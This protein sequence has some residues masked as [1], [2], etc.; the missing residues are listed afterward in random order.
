MKNL[1]TIIPCLLVAASSFSQ[2]SWSLTGNAG[3]N[4]STSFIGTTDNTPFVFKVGGG[5]PAGFSGY[6]ENRNVSYGYRSLLNVANGGTGTGLTAIGYGALANNTSGEF[7]TALG[8]WALVANTTGYWNV[9]L[10][11]GALQW[12][13]TGRFNSAGGN[14]S[15]HFNETGIENTAFGEQ[16]LGGNLDGNFNTAVGCRSLW[17]VLYTPGVGDSGYGHSECNTAVGYESLKVITKGGWNVGVGVRALQ[18]NSAGSDN[19]AVGGL[20]LQRNTTGIGNTAVGNNALSNSKT[21]NY[22]TAIGYGANIN[23]DDITNSTAIGNGAMV[24][25]SNQIVIGNKNVTSIRLTVLPSA[26]SDRRV[27]ENIQENVPGLKFIKLLR[28]V[29]YH[30][31]EN[32]LDGFLKSEKGSELFLGEDAM[33]KS[34]GAIS[35]I[36]TGFIAQEVESAA[37]SIGYS[38][39]AIDVP[40]NKDESLYGLR[41]AKFV[42]PIVKSVQELS[43]QNDVQDA[44]FASMQK[45]VESLQKQVEELTKLLNRLMENN[46]SV[47]KTTA[48]PE[49]SLEQNFPN[50]FTQTATINYTL[51]QNFYMAKIVITDTSGRV[52]KQVALSQPGSGFLTVEA[53]FLP[54]GMYYYSLYVDNTLTDT[55]KM[56]ITK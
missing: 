16:S 55:K 13:K 29:T 3:T 8:H 48:A 37:N 10:G 44:A 38:F 25:S 32:A 18:S 22:N 11:S 39:C 26:Y 49:A 52:F 19:V 30:I 31:N 42:V 45:Q 46:T 1:F 36:R 56:I 9:A 12:N 53:G 47:P 34:D 14:C 27:K 2:T 50:P 21:G 51:P 20:A 15:L 5:N 4:P 23:H 43:A 28:P 17:S 33:T 41:Y 7:N 54:A 24:T 35:K 6:S 40:A